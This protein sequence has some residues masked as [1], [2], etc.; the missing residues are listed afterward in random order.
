MTRTANVRSL[1]AIEQ[2]RSALVLFAEDAEGALT[3]VRGQVQ[4]FVSWLKDEQRGYW[5]HQIRV[6]E[7][8]VLEAKA[9]LSRCMAAT[10][11]PRRTPTCYQEKKVL[12]AAKRA[13]EEAE[14]KLAAVR[15]WMPIIDQAVSDYFGRAETM[16]S[17]VAVDVPRA[18]AHLDR[19]LT[20]LVEYEQVALPADS[21]GINRRDAE[22]AEQR[23]FGVTTTSPLSQSASDAPQVAPRAADQDPDAC[24]DSPA[25]P[26]KQ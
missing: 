25:A 21:G 1:E 16:A 5:E 10:I 22:G 24:Q 18:V 6:R 20:A 2:V 7:E 12:A 3:T 19:L 17:A 8:R 15:R 14:E 23:Q 11:D 13:L 4:D 9:D 26:P